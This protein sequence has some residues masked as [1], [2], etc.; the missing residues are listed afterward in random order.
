MESH[1]PSGMLVSNLSRPE[2][3]SPCR[4]YLNPLEIIEPLTPLSPLQICK[5]AAGWV[6]R[7][8]YQHPKQINHRQPK[9]VVRWDRRMRVEW[10][11]EEPISPAIAYQRDNDR[12]CMNERKMNQVVK[13]RHLSKHQKSLED[14]RRA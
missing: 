8:D 10:T 14:R 12:Q 3:F 5:P 9:S 2:K 6:Q 1:S 13:K 11:A 4:Q 7:Y